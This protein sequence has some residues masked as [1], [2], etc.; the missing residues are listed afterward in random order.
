MDRK[1]LA[2]FIMTGCLF[3]TGC[4]STGS[5]TGTGGGLSSGCCG[6][7]SGGGLLSRLF[8]GGSNATTAAPVA[9]AGS[10]GTSMGGSMSSS[11]GGVDCPCSHQGGG[12]G[13]FHPAVMS[14]SVTGGM[15]AMGGGGP[16]TGDMG[17]P[18]NFPIQNMPMQ[19]APIQGAP[20]QGGMIQGAP[21]QGMQPYPGQP[22]SISTPGIPPNMNQPGIPGQPPRIQPVP[23]APSGVA[24]S[25]GM[26]PAAPWGPQ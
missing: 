4:S 22:G 15:P 12:E 16:V 23:M 9:Y 25:S 2:A 14:G 21:I 26:A 20:I 24:P 11:M 1:K 19:G 18:Q 8:G 13:M 7:G 6:H 10:M 5:S 17:G 3:T